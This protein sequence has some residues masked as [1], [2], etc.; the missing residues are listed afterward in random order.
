MAVDQDPP[1]PQGR[2]LVLMVNFF[3]GTPVFS[4]KSEFLLEQVMFLTQTIHEVG[5]VVFLA[6]ADNLSVNKKMFK[7]LHESNKSHS[8]A[9]IEHHLENS[10]FKSFRLFYDPT[11]TFKSIRDNWMTEKIQTLDFQDPDKIDVS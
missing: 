3:F 6:M 9:A 10:L 7:L 5:G 11:H 8:I 2:V 4:F 1:K